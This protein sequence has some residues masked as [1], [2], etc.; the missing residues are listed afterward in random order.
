MMA[1][2][3]RAT[4]TG[5]KIYVQETLTRTFRAVML[6]QI[7]GALHRPASVGFA[8]LQFHG[9][10]SPGPSHEQSMNPFS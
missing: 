4:A 3:I 8:G 9:L 5:I 1:F 6:G 10:K 7:K 2:P